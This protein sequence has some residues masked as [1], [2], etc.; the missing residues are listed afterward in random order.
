[1]RQIGNSI[2]TC[3]LILFFTETIN[4]QYTINNVYGDL[5]ECDTMTRDIYIVWWD[6]DFDFS[7]EVDELLDTMVEHRNTCLNELNMMD[8]PNPIDGYYYNVYIHT[9]GDFFAPYG[10]GN[11]QGTDT[12]GYPFLTLPFGVIGDLVNTGHETF[13]IFQYNANSPGFA[14]SG[15]SQWYI[16]ASANWFG[17][18][19]NIEAPRAFIESESLVRLPQVPLWLSYD[20]FPNSYP[21]NWQRYVHQ[22]A[23]ALFLYY[24]T[25]EVNVSPNLL[26]EGFYVGTTE[27][28]QEYLFN[29][30]GASDFRNHFI[31]WAAHMT[32]DFDFITP[33]QAAANELEWDNYAD[34]ADDFEYIEIF[35][36]D[37]TNGWY[38]PD[39]AATTNAWSFNTY[40]IEN[41]TDALYTFEINGEELGTYGDASY[42]QAKVVVKNSAGEATFY[43]V[44]MNNDWNGSLSLNLI[45]S[46]TNVYFIVA[47]M[48]E[49]F[50]DSNADFQ[51]FPYEIRIS[52]TVL[53]I[54]GFENEDSE[55]IEI[56]RYNFIGQKINKNTSGLQIILYSDGTNKKIYKQ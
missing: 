30:I 54:A 56:G 32:N 12:N 36:E 39:D 43:D 42:F 51:R 28:P 24:L 6:N 5:T 13:H 44:P 55:K 52:N 50:E 38:Q 2:A 19:Q 7:T 48:P 20:N 46:D 40:K 26:T 29:Q 45:T 22:Y 35:D 15:D 14:Y 18:I 34:P 1:M 53:G 37:G 17:A 11:G 4:A 31:D 16:E 27:L 33:E 10:W 41:P 3:L 47:S 23:M 8:P 49:V 25:D 21:Q 9:P